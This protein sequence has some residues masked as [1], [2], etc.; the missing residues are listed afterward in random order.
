MTQRIFVV[1]DELAGLRRAHVEGSIGNFYEVMADPTDERFENLRDL[2]LT[3]PDAQPSVVNDASAAGYF[4]SDAAVRV[5]LLSQHVRTAAGAPLRQMLEPLW[6][7]A[8]RVERLRAHFL[9]AFP[10]P[11]FVIDFLA[12]RPRLNEVS[13]SSA[14]FLDL[15]LE[16][17]SPAPVDSVKQYLRALS[18]QAQDT[19]LPPLVLMSTHTELQEHRRNFSEHARI[20]AAGLMIL[21]KEKIAEPQFGALGLRLSFDQLARQSSTAHSMRRFLFSWTAALRRASEETSKTLWNLDASAMQQIHLASVRDSDPY[22]EHLG[23]LLSRDHLHRI[24]T[25]PEVKGRLQ[26]LDATF[27][28]NLGTDGKE[29]SNRLIAPLIDVANARALMS[30]FT[31]MGALPTAPL[32][33]YLDVECAERIS[34]SLPF[35]TVLCRRSID[36]N[37]RFLVHITQQCD[38]NGMSRDK[39]PNGTLIFALAE[40]QE[41]LSSDNPIPTSSD[42]VLKGLQVADSG[43]VREFD[44]T[45]LRGELLAMPLKDFLARARQQQLR[46]AGRLRSDICNQIVAATSNYLSRPASQLMLRPGVLRSKIFLQSKSLPGGKAALLETGAKARIFSLTRD[47]DLFS[48]Q[49]EACV[50]IALWLS[51]QL[52][53]LGIHVQADP[54]CTKLRTGWRDN[55]RLPGDLLVRVRDCASLDNAWKSLV[56]DDVVEDQVQ[57]TIVFE[58]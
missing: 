43:A 54:L 25:D 48:F 23:E 45:V 33:S 12:A 13:Q 57:L 9:A 10:P 18:D 11:E 42:L 39:N 41:L 29:I 24:E 34:R 8:A 55:K 20:S 4:A 27:R 7:R 15:F 17:G 19:V 47:D 21:P 52:P 44:L 36:R 46:V 26:N 49:D 35:G 40:A 16:D 1:D 53:A 14:V 2:A 6:D 30:H 22:D 38:L 58:K 50:D 28:E 51:S 56:K 5:L 32:L 37:D 31:W 3:V